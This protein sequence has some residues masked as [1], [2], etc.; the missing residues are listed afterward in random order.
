[1]SGMDAAVVSSG[2]AVGDV[3]EIE[4]LEVLG[5]P[6]RFRF[7][8]SAPVSGGDIP[9]LGNASYDPDA[10]ITVLASSAP[11]LRGKVT[12]QRAHLS[13]DSETSWVD[14]VGSDRSVEMF[15]PELTEDGDDAGATLTTPPWMQGLLEPRP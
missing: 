3:S 14:V 6:T 10:T 13:G 15:M 4:V 7:R 9:A 2:G 11:M 1:M 5:E 8:V 12:G